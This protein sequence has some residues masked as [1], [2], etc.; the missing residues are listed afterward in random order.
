MSCRIAMASPQKSCSC[1]NCEPCRDDDINAPSTACTA[2]TACT[3]S[4]VLH[5]ALLSA[6]AHKRWDPRPG[7]CG[8]AT[9]WPC[10]MCCPAGAPPGSTHLAADA[11]AWPCHMCCPAGPPPGSTHLAADAGNM[12]PHPQMQWAHHQHCVPILGYRD[13]AG[14]QMGPELYSMALGGYSIGAQLILKS[15]S[16]CHHL[17]GW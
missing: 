13:V 1:Q 10:H 14:T 15:S 7:A 9:A 2:C 3:A 5:E 6:Q 16:C 17:N 8:V 12:H 4:Q 11:A